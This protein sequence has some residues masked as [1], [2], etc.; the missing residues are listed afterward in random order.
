MAVTSTV[1]QDIIDWAHT[2]QNY[3]AANGEPAPLDDMM[4]NTVLDLHQLLKPESSIPPGNE[5]GNTDW[6]SLLNRMILPTD[7]KLVLSPKAHVG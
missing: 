7:G 2:Q 3:E 5:L 6:I 4:R 1:Y